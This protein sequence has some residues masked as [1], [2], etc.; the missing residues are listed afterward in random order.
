MTASIAALRLGS[1]GSGVTDIGWFKPDGEEMSDQDWNAS[2]ARTVGVFLNGKG[3]PTPDHRGEPI[4]DDSFYLLFNANYEPIDFKLPTC[5]WG[6][7]WETVIDTGVPVPDLRQHHL[8]K[9]GETLKVQA[10]S[11]VVLRRAA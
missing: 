2:F 9:A 3:I 10:Y 5:P 7:A 8:W 1:R 6:D 11:V 4:V